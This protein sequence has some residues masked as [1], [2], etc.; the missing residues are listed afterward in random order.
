M[1]SFADLARRTFR[2]ATKSQMDSARNKTKLAVTLLEDRTVPATVEGTIFYDGNGDGTQDGGENYAE[3]IGVLLSGADGSSQTG[4][5]DSLGHYAFSGVSPASY[6]VIVTGAPTGYTVSGNGSVSV[7]NDTDDI[8]VGFAL[9]GGA[10]SGSGSGVIDG[11]AFYDDNGNQVQDTGERVASGI[12]VAVTPNGGG[13]MTSYTDANG[14]YSFA[15]LAPGSYAVAFTPPAEYT[16][17]TPVGGSTNVTVD[18]DTVGVGVGL[19]SGSSSTSGSQTAHIDFDVPWDSID[20]DQPSQSLPLSNFSLSLAGQTFTS[21]NATFITSPTIQLANGTETGVT[22][23]IDTSAVT[24]YQY[25]S[26]SMNGEGTL[27]AI[28]AI[29]HAPVNVIVLADNVQ[30]EVDFAQAK[31]MVSYRIEIKL[32]NKPQGGQQVG[33]T[34]II[35]LGASATVDDI[36]GFFKGAMT[37]LGLTCDFPAGNSKRAVISG[38]AAG[39]NAFGVILYKTQVLNTEGAWMDSPL[40]GPKFVGKRQSPEFYVNG[41]ELK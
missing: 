38:P 9:E 8:G 27:T 20:P 31:T 1:K 29:T 10:G 5:T 7:V 12:Q 14:N 32:F 41:T 13:P 17:D 25:S 36:R 19:S 11:I 30:F 33:T 4:T 26:L 40:A 3:G 24:G 18:N 15:N 6:T 22:F 34:Q 28:D 37:D 21:A 39:A 16:V 2:R 35:T 23:A